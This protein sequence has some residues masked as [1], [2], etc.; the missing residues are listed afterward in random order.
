MAG[1]VGRRLQRRDHRAAPA[2]QRPNAPTPADSLLTVSAGPLPPGAQPECPR[3]VDRGNEAVCGFRYE[4]YF[5]AVS[6][7]VVGQ[8]RCLLTI[9]VVA[10]VLRSRKFR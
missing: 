5:G 4:V 7:A 6:I 3:T 1:L 9:R 10:G 8:S 2:P